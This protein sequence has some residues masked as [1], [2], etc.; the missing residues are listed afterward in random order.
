MDTLRNQFDRL[1]NSK[2]NNLNEKPIVVICRISKGKVTEGM[3]IL[4]QK[5]SILEF[6]FKYNI[7]PHN[8]KLELLSNIEFFKYQCSARFIN[9]QLP[10]INALKTYK[11]WKNYG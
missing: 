5:Q 8:K 6:M 1:N 9:E 3:S 2:W 4:Q 7:K 11:I 10:M